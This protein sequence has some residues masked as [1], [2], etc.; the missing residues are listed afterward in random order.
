[1]RQLIERVSQSE[2][3]PVDLSVISVGADIIS[4][5]LPSHCDRQRTLPSY[6]LGMSSKVQS[7]NPA[8]KNQVMVEHPVGF[9]ADKN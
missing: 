7:D 1:M 4:R 2:C 3:D 9:V 8:K 5:E 6:A